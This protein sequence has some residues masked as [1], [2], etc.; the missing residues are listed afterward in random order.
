MTRLWTSCRPLVVAAAL[1]VLVP[2]LACTGAGGDEGAVPDSAA[3]VAVIDTL[4]VVPPPVDTE[5]MPT[6]AL[7]PLADSIA[8]L[9]VFAPVV[10]SWFT[11]AAR[12]KAL[13][14]DLG[15]IDIDLR[16]DPTRIAAFRRAAE[17]RSPTRKGTKFRLHGPWGADSATLTG[18]EQWNGRIVATLAAPARVDSIARVMDPLVVAAERVLAD[19]APTTSTCDRSADSVFQKRVQTLADSVEQALRDGDQPPYPRLKQSLHTRKSMAMG[20][21]FAM[22]TTPPAPLAKG[23]KAPVHGRAI[24]IVTFWAGDYGW[25]R[26][27]VLLVGDSLMRPLPVRDLRFRAH[28]ALHALDAD[29]DG[30]DDLATRAWTPRGGG[31]S[32]MRLVDGARLERLTSGFAWER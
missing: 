20:C 27:R 14:L 13:Y 9:L 15:R 8:Q 1:L 10:E 22:D 7:P 5:P 25:V 16:K 24:L 23:Q 11:A 12:A 28:E 29:G 4:P 21:F 31:T 18:F 19:S 30:I 17:A 3:N 6:T 2:W 26:E 32:V